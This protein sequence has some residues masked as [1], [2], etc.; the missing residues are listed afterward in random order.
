M[1]IIHVF[2]LGLRARTLCV[3]VCVCVCV[4]YRLFITLLVRSHTPTY[5]IN[6]HKHPRTFDQSLILQSFFQMGNQI[7]L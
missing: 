4:S 7:I 3:C 6:L 2:L 5:L 1:T